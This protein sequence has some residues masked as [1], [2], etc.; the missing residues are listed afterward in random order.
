M[1]EILINI[2]YIIIIIISY[3]SYGHYIV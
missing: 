2:N 1:F 3:G